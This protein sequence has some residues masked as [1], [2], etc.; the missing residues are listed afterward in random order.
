MYYRTGQE[1]VDY[2][3][4]DQNNPLLAE[5]IKRKGATD[6]TSLKAYGTIGGQIGGA[7]ACAALGAAA[8]S[9]FCATIGGYIGG[10]LA[11]QIPIAKGTSY[12]EAI[13]QQWATD[14]GP[15]NAG[16]NK[17]I[18]SVLAYLAYRDSV[19]T[20]ANKNGQGSK[21]TI[22]KRLADSGIPGAPV[23]NRWKPNQARWLAY[24]CSKEWAKKHENDEEAKAGV[25]L[26]IAKSGFDYWMLKNW[27]SGP[28]APGKDPIDWGLV[29]H[30]YFVAK[31]KPKDSWSNKPFCEM[32]AA[33][34]GVLP[35]S[36]VNPA[37]KQFLVA[38][39]ADYPRNV[40][41]PYLAK[42]RWIENEIVGANKKSS[43]AG[44]AI[45]I[46]GLGVLGLIALVKR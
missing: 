40:V 2:S 9:P 46:A 41:A 43:G 35:K 42:L 37:Y 12:K 1:Y 33:E 45:A 16:A 21:E 15:W 4:Y 28:A 26:G 30:D 19:I 8:A 25:S 6:E 23:S 14:L 27:I 17:E 3:G 29:G 22:A 20:R 13:Q 10:W 38:T 32:V 5:M 24:E 7:A 11:E 36:Y 34:K 18:Q 31:V 44:P 39:P